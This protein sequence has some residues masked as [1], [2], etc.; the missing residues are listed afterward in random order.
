[1]K[2]MLH[3]L[4]KRFS[5]I[6]ASIE[7]ILDVNSM[8]VED[9]VS[10]LKPSEDCIVV[11]EITEQ[12]GHL[13]LTEEEWLSKYRH[14]LQGKSSS[15]SGRDRAGGSNLAM[16]KG[17]GGKK[18][19]VIKLTTEGTPRQKGRCQNCGIYGHWKQDC[20]CPKKDRREESHHV[21][22]EVVEQLA[23]LLVTVNVM[24][25]EQIQH[26][27]QSAMQEIVYLNEEKVYPQGCDD[28][29]D[30]WVLDTGASNHMMGRREALACLCEARCT[31]GIGHLLRLKALSQSCS[32]PGRLATRYSLRS[33]SFQ[34]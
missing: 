21:K 27:A 6:A 29:K 14:R 8:T 32:R 11:E 28:D 1:V 16:Q 26:G 30:S 25:V 9:L 22:T 3:V 23:L 10:Q 13:M 20:K 7:T 33:T 19:P 24:P 12:T 5:Q 15:S 18:D 31:S 34:S 17:S 4:P 2:K